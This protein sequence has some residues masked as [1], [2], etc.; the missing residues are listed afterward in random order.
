MVF[1]PASGAAVLWPYLVLPAIPGTNDANHLARRAIL[2]VPPDSPIPHLLRTQ[3][4]G[5][6]VT[7]FSI[8]PAIEK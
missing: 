4:E 3:A 8:V 6:D 5:S 2:A 7:R 1:L